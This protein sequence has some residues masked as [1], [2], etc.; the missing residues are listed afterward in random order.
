MLFEL[1]RA[2][3]GSLKDHSAFIEL[4]DNDTAALASICQGELTHMN[5]MRLGSV[6]VGMAW[7][8]S[9]GDWSLLGRLLLGAPC[10]SGTLCIMGF[11]GDCHWG[12]LGGHWGATH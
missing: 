11:K 2:M 8:W 7:V 1:G 9:M 4:F 6:G 5:D 10:R 3:P 12:L